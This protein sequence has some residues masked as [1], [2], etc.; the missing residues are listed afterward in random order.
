M[1]DGLPQRLFLGL[2]Q[3]RGRFLVEAGGIFAV[4][5]EHVAEQRGRHLIMPAI[6]DVGVPGKGARGHLIGEQGVTSGIGEGEPRCRAR[7]QP[8]DRGA[9]DDVR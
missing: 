3:G 5:A 7:T 6:G 4:R 1:L 8:L 2:L 9:N